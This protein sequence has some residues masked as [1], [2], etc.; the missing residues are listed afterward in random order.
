MN[1]ATHEWI[2]AGMMVAIMVMALGVLAYAELSSVH[3]RRR[4][5]QR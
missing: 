4:K 2:A 1:M 3:R 5:H